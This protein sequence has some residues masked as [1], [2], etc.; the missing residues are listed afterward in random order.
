MKYWP[1]SDNRRTNG[2][3]QKNYKIIEERFPDVIS[4][5]KAAQTAQIE[6]VF[7]ENENKD[8]IPFAKTEQ[9]E[10]RLNS[11]YEPLRAAELFAERYA[12]DSDYKVYAI[13]GLSDGKC[14]R[15]LYRS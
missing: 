13:A 15:Q 10:Y 9:G 12:V 8:C 1:L 6:L 4:K 7:V 11:Y 3:I 5:L 2:Q 14:I